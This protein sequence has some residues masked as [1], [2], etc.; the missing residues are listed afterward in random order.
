MQIV[1]EVI[2]AA[3]DDILAA[4]QLIDEMMTIRTIESAEAQHTRLRETRSQHGLLSAEDRI[5]RRRAADRRGFINAAA[6]ILSIHA[7]GAGE[8]KA[9]GADFTSPRKRALHANIVS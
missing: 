6:V 3:A 4:T 9:A 2:H 5:R 8:N 1:D 7:R